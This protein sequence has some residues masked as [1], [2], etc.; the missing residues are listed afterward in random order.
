MHE[1]KHFPEYIHS[2]FCSFIVVIPTDDIVVQ[3][4]NYLYESI[5]KDKIR[6]QLDLQ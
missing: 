2:L 3:W 4:V 1:Q 6:N 5:H